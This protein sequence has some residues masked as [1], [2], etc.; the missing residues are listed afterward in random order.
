[1]NINPEFEAASLMSM[2]VD[3]AHEDVVVQRAK[4][5]GKKWASRAYGWPHFR[6]PTRFVG[7]AWACLQMGADPISGDVGDKGFLVDDLAQHGMSLRNHDGR[8]YLGYNR[9]KEV[10]WHRAMAIS[11]QKAADRHI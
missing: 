1:M 9:L 6:T 11:L 4:H 5:T 7:A 8:R 10:E 2:L 3:R